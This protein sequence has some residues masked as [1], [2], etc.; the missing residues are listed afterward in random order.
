ML[1]TSAGKGKEEKISASSTWSLVHF[2]THDLYS[3]NKFWLRCRL[4]IPLR[5]SLGLFKYHTVICILTLSIIKR[6][7]SFSTADL[8]TPLLGIDLGFTAE[9]KSYLY[10][11]TF[12]SHLYYSLVHQSTL[13]FLPL[14]VS[15][16]MLMSIGWMIP[17]TVRGN[18]TVSSSDRCVPGPFSILSLWLQRVAMPA[19][20][21]AW[22][23]MVGTWCVPAGTCPQPCFSQWVSLTASGLP[24]GRSL[25]PHFNV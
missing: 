20:G 12:S 15:Y 14:T 4:H 5:K 7:T 13:W 17:E 16:L 24:A 6:A 21:N 19:K 22:W 1:I 2:C 23:G 11:L 18:E 10:C 3:Q 9:G 8:T 25:I